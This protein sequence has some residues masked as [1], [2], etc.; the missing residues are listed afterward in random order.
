MLIG[1]SFFSTKSFSE[2]IPSWIKNN[3]KWWDEG[4]ISEYEFVSSLEFLI[5]EGILKVPPTSASEEKSDKIPDW[6]KNNAKWW[7][8]NQI[9]DIEFL[10][11]IQYLMSVGIISIEHREKSLDINEETIFA[12]SFDLSKAGAIE[13]NSKAPFT[14]IMFSDHQCEKCALWLKHEKQVLMKNIVEEG[15]ANFFLLDYPFLGEDSKSAAEA[16]YCAEDQ[17]KFAQYLDI[18]ATKHNGIQTGWANHNS[19]VNF[20]A[21]I[22]LDTEEFDQCL[23]WDRYALRVDHNRKVASAHGI[24]GTPV[25]FVISPEGVEKRIAGPQPPMIFESIIDELS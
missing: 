13:G 9:S 2:D 10:N 6:V 11:G 1:I 3:A 5:K 18:L 23:F 12:G 7:G 20:A 14:I 4:S 24:V 21:E 17:G 19:L 15:K 8:N 25:F 22:G 16:T